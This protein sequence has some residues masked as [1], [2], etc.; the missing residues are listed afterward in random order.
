MIVTA[1]VMCVLVGNACSGS[2][3][4]PG[5]SVP[6]GNV[7]EGKDA[8]VLL[9]IFDGGEGGWCLMPVA[10]AGTNVCPSFHLPREFGPFDGPIITE[11]WNSSVVSGRYD[12]TAL[13]LTASD[14]AAV[15]F[16]GSAPIKT[17]ADRL[18]DHLRAALVEIHGRKRIVNGIAFPAPLPR[19]RLI[20]ISFGGKPMRD[21]RSPGPPLEF[22]VPSESWGGSRSVQG[23]CALRVEG[24]SPGLIYQGG[25]VMTVIGAHRDVRGQEF[26]DCIRRSYVQGGWPL[27]ANILLS[28]ARPGST[29][30]VLP[31]MRRLSRGSGIWIFGTGK[32]GRQVARRVR[33]GWLVVSGGRNLQQRLSM[34]SYLRAEVMA[35]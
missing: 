27:E 22:S 11:L 17:H 9:P 33:G 10:A 26:V 24:G 34:L 14:V 12:D 28:A 7:V 8:V 4:A 16:R 32:E 21:M 31:L 30:P 25:S 13:V 1:M 18:P 19:T 23:V 15:T 29:P 20:P 2:A 5:G 6:R 35:G 3:D